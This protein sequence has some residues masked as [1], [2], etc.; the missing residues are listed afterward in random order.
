MKRYEE[1]EYARGSI[2]CREARAKRGLSLVK[3]QKKTGHNAETWRGYE[4]SGA[5]RTIDAYDVVAGELGWL[6]DELRHYIRTG[7]RPEDNPEVQVNRIK[8]L[9]SRL[10]KEVA[11]ALVSD[12]VALI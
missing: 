12:L 6:L 1:E 8:L 10:P 2:I 3:F 7:E 5:I 11:K 4:V 9:F